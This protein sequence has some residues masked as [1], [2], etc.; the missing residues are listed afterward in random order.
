MDQENNPVAHQG[1]TVPSA[2]PSLLNVAARVGRYAASTVVDLLFPKRCVGCDAEGD[3]ICQSCLEDLPR[4]EPPYCFLC[5]RPG[6]L[7]LGLCPHCRDRPLEIAGIR[8]PYRMEGAIR[9]AVHAL[10]YRNVRALAPTLGQ[11]LADFMEAVSMPADII[12]PVPL[13]PKRERSRGY[14]QSLLLAKEVSGWSG[15]PLAA[16]ALRR[17]RWAVSQASSHDED[18]R[19]ANVQGAFRA[20][21]DDMVR[22]K[23]VVVIDDVCTTGATLEACSIALKQAGATSVWGLTLAKEA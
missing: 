16:G 22:G 14:N 7:K 19:W 1:E 18:Q 20:E 12:V 8:S 23:R 2:R 10:K 4:L 3:F 5:A 6:S 11:L 21:P 13:H 17:E 9:E 15:V